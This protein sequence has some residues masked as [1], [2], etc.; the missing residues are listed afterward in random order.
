MSTNVWNSG[1]SDPAGTI[2]ASDLD[3]AIRQLRKD[4]RERLLQGGKKLTDTS[5][6]VASENNDGK[7]CVGIEDSVGTDAGIY[8]MFW[9]FGGTNPRGRHYGGSHASK[10]NRTEFIGDVAPLS[11]TTL[12]K[13]FGIATAAYTMVAVGDPLPVIGYLKRVLWKVPNSVSYPQ[14]TVKSFRLT[15][16]TR[17]VGANLVAELRFRDA[18]AGQADD[19]DDPF[20]DG[21]TTLITTATLTTGGN[22]SVLVSGLSQALDADDELIIKYTSVGTT[23][24]AADTTGLVLME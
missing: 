9:D 13:F 10:P 15:T 17:P 2:N 24:N 1:D 23:T 20:V 16:G 6:G 22:Y 19:N 14:R 21:N 5:R 18:S 3:N 8:T 4:V 12:I 11:P 7:A